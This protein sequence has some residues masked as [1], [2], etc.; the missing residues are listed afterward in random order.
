MYLSHHL[1]EQGP[2]KTRSVFLHLPLDVSQVLGQR[3]PAASL[4]ATQSAA[5]ICLLL[6]EIAA[7]EGT[8]GVA[9]A[10][11]TDQA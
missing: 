6:S 4:P 2:L 11:P 5:A 7:D 8:E 10:E 9:S 3:E 1:A